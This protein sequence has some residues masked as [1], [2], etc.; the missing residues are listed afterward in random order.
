MTEPSFDFSEFHPLDHV[1]GTPV[2]QSFYGGWRRHFSLWHDYQAPDP[3]GVLLCRLGRHER[4]EGWSSM[5]V[6]DNGNGE[7]DL[8]M[9]RRC[10]IDLDSP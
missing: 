5:V 7:P 1:A 3:I 9:C 6:F 2:C 4:T 10:L 8:A